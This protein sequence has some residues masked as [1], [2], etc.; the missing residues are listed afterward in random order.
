MEA[1]NDLE[2]RRRQPINNQN[3]DSME[4]EE[5]MISEQIAIEETPIEMLRLDRQGMNNEISQPETGAFYINKYLY[6]EQQ[7]ASKALSS[8][9]TL[10]QQKRNATTQEYDANKLFVSSS[11]KKGQNYQAFIPNKVK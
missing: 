7:A 5:P 10:N 4:Q 3:S 6:A 8:L 1:R 11:N 9:T 2:T